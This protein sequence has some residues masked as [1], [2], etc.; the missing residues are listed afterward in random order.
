MCSVQESGSL[1]VRKFLKL[2][3]NTC[4]V[5]WLDKFR[6]ASRCIF[7]RC[8][9]TTS[10]DVCRYVHPS[11]KWYAHTTPDQ[12]SQP[13][14]LLFFFVLLLFIH[15]LS[16][17]FQQLHQ[18]R[19][20]GALVLHVPRPATGCAS[21]SIENAQHHPLER[22]RKSARA[23]RSLMHLMQKNGRARGREGGLHPQYASTSHRYSA[24]NGRDVWNDAE[25]GGA[26]AGRLVGLAE[27]QP[28]LRAWVSARTQHA[29]HHPSR[30]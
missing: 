11:G 10:T 28:T 13:D 1:S 25:A 23:H 24:N 3:R 27:M 16:C 9:A 17:C 18:K 15:A 20:D 19:N 14:V 8:S 22:P 7:P 5:E 2:N 6:P 12:T 29:P 30:L 26:A 4:A 21:D